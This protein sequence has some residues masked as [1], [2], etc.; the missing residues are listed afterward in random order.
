[1]QYSRVVSAM[2]VLTVVFAFS[3]HAENKFVGTKACSMCHKGGKGG[4]AYSVWEKSA[5][6][7][8]YQTLLGDAAKKVAKEKGLKVAANEAPECLKC[9]VTGGGAAKNVDASFKKEEG[10]GCESC[11]GAGS[12]FKMAHVGGDLAKAKAA[13]MI[14]PAKDE[15]LCIT[16]HN[17]ESP[18]K[19]AFKFAESWAKIEHGKPVKK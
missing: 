10:I 7:K 16:C 1:M 11:H 4:T 18:T 8:A 5:H 3:M 2:L 13:G 9:H 6:A 14:I 15:K 12:S 17:D 19:K